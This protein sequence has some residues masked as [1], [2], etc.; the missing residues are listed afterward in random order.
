MSVTRPTRSGFFAAAVVA[1]VVVLAAADD[2]V[3]SSPPQA[4]RRSG[5]NAQ[6]S[7]VTAHVHVRRIAYLPVFA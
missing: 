3:S 6:M 1:A 5:R 7:A 4:K 2:S